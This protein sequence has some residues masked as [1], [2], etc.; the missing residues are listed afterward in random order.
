[1]TRKV[2]VRPVSNLVSNDV[3]SLRREFAFVYGKIAELAEVLVGVYDKREIDAMLRLVDRRPARIR[4][5]SGF[6]P[7]GTAA[8]E[9]TTSDFDAGG[10]FDID[11]DPTGMTFNFGGVF[12]VRGFV[13]WSG[14]EG[15]L[16]LLAND[17]E[18]IAEG[19]HSVE[20]MR[21]F[22]RGDFVQLVVDQDV[23][24]G[25]HSPVLEI[26]YVRPNLN[27]PRSD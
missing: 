6:S 3:G 9:F 11:T 26:E 4:R 15:T 2:D 20:T 12:R 21:F 8:I 14:A 5:T 22:K 1:M 17:T 16:Q 25:L 19:V 23:E 27:L 13:A 24:G 10:Y 18:L 7:G